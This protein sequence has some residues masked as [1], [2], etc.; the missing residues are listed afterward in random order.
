MTTKEFE[1]FLHKNLNA[2]YKAYVETYGEDKAYLSIFCHTD[3]E[4]K[5]IYIS[6]NNNYWEEG[7]KFKLNCFWGLDDE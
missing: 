4:G 6:A 1:E 3:E 5:G 7:P 2:I